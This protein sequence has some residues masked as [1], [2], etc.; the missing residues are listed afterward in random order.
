MKNLRIELIKGTHSFQFGSGRLIDIESGEEIGGAIQSIKLT[1]SVDNF[2][3]AEIVFA[4]MQA[5]AEL[6]ELAVHCSCVCPGCGLSIQIPRRDA[7]VVPIS[8]QE[9]ALDKPAGKEETS[10]R[11]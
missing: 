8:T 5:I 4:G 7:F 1:S 11:T 3:Q 6:P 9:K 2:A 10:S